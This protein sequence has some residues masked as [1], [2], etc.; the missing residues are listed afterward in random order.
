MCVLLIS[1]NPTPDTALVILHNRDEFLNRPFEKA[2][3]HT[4]NGESLIFGTDLVG[5]GTWL[6]VNK[7]GQF[8]AVLN[9]RTSPNQPKKPK[10]RGVLPIEV[11]SYRKDLS[12]Y[13]NGLVPDEYNPFNLVVGG[14]DTTINVFS[15]LKSIQRSFEAPILGLSNNSIDQQWEK[16][17][18]IESNFKTATKS[19]RSEQE[20]V[21]TSFDLLAEQERLPDNLLPTTGYPPTIETFLSSAF[22]NISASK[23]QTVV[24]TVITVKK[25][26]Q[27]HLYEK[28]HLRGDHIHEVSF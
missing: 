17:R 28:N 4:S 15:S 12:S 9:I 6:A 25:G 2:A 10:S 26:G 23:Y 3:V 7:V 13:F 11:L 21:S 24:S 18:R 16:A 27:V 20:L 8:A 5:G 1:R 14:A 19:L 22:V